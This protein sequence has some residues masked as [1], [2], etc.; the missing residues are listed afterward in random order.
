MNLNEWSLTNITISIVKPVRPYVLLLLLGINMVFTTIFIPWTNVLATT[1]LSTNFELSIKCFILGFIFSTINSYI[2]LLLK[3]R[4]TIFTINLKCRFMQKICERVY[5][6]DWLLFKEC[7]KKQLPNKINMARYAFE[8]YID[9]IFDIIHIIFDL[10]GT[11]IVLLNIFP[12]LPIVLFFGNLIV[13]YFNTLPFNK[14][15]LIERQSINKESDKIWQKYWRIMHVAEEK[16]IHHQENE[17]TD[18]VV[19]SQYGRQQAWTSLSYKSSVSNF[20][21]SA[22]NKLLILTC[23]LYFVHVNIFP[24]SSLLFDN[25]FDIS[26]VNKELLL[27]IVTLNIYMSNFMDTINSFISFYTEYERCNEDYRGLYKILVKCDLRPTNEQIELKHTFGFKNINFTFPES[28][29]HS[30]KEWHL[31]SEGD[32]EFKI[33]DSVLVSGQ[34]GAGKS[35]FYNILNGTIPKNMIL[36][37]QVFIDGQLTPDKFHNGEGSRTMVLQDSRCDTDA[38]CYE[39]VTGQERDGDD[40]FTKSN[41]FDTVVWELLNVVMLSDLFKEEFNSNIYCKIKDKLSGGQKTRLLLARALFRASDRKSKI[42]V[43]DEPDKGL[44]PVLAVEIIKNIMQ[45]SH[46]K[47]LFLTLHNEKVDGLAITHVIEV[48]DGIIKM[49][50]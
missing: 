1:K 21:T 8:A 38:S 3:N 49:K 47:I 36:E 10:V 19:K 41:S 46:D 33:G 24:I 44:Q 42:L 17:I 15:H 30:R 20:K 25:T 32:F 31:R 26:K 2:G 5:S 35:T 13:Y 23:M 29:K 4:Q 40:I 27:I 6:T 18:T 16:V 34:S 50:N 37:C 14:T 39:I 7:E 11:L 12:L 45:W 22:A 43:L 48:S 9:N 28:K